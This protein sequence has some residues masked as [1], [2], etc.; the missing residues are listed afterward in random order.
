MKPIS[1]F[2]EIFIN[3]NKMMYSLIISE[4]LNDCKYDTQYR[5]GNML[6]FVYAV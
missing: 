3:P 6:R 2:K 1:L 5:K 4:I